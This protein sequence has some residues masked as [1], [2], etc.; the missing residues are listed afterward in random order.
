MAITCP[1]CKYQFEIKGRTKPQN[2]SYWG[3][4]VTPFAEHLGYETDECHVL[5]KENCNF[6]ME[7]KTDKN[8]IMRELKRVLST[9][10]MTTVQ[11]SEYE[12]RCRQF[13][14]QW[15]CQCQEPNEPPMEDR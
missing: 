1:K 14:L 11:F 15:G 8:G 9:T 5:L 7:H 6:V 4:I 2:D 10:G 12:S 13:A 3:L